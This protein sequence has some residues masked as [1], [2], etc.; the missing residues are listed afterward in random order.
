LQ[1]RTRREFTAQYRAEVAAMVL[2][3]GKSRAEVARELD[4]N[5]SLVGKWV[6][7]AVDGRPGCPGQRPRGGLVGSGREGGLEAENLRLRRE[8]EFLK[9]AAAFFARQSQ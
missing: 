6:R 3:L 2:E 8:K 5:E 1:L 4:L 9:K 7:A